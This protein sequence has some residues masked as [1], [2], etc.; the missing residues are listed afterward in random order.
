MSSCVASIVIINVQYNYCVVIL[1][2]NDLLLLTH[3]NN[4]VIATRAVPA[5]HDIAFNFS[6]VVLRTAVDNFYCMR[7]Y[8]V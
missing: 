7:P 5:M 4:V 3:N 2:L 1:L 8:I 6:G